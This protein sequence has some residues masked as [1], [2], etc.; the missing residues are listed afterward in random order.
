MQNYD[1]IFLTNIP[2][3]YKCDLYARIAKH[4]R[5]LVIFLAK[6]SEHRTEDFYKYSTAFATLILSEETVEQRSI[7]SNSRRL[8]WQLQ[9]IKT[10]LLVLGGWDA[11]EYWVELFM[12]RAE[13]RAIVL[14]SSCFESKAI[15]I[16]GYLK[17]LFIKKVELAFPSGEAHQRLL[18]SIGFRGRIQKTKGVGIFHYAKKVIK[19]TVFRG[20]FLYV[21]RLYANH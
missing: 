9:K 16:K 7:V 21:G 18:E 11:P 6:T 20:N 13:K 8:C 17:S 19:E 14:E 12:A 15:G 5:I 1:I 3:F 4:A 2:A 10:K